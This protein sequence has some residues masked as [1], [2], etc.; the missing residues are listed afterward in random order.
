MNTDL[1]L[2]Q[3]VQAELR[4]EPALESGQIGVEAKN[5][6]VTLAGVVASYAVQWSAERAARRV[7]GVQALVARLKVRLPALYR[8]SDEDIARSACEVVT[9]ATSMPEGTVKVRVRAGRIT[10]SGRVDWPYQI[11]QAGDS[12]RYLRGVTGLNNRIGLRVRSAPASAEAAGRQASSRSYSHL[13]T[14]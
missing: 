7:A 13:T 10:L 14:V 8:R 9:S 4:W 12:V 3:A 1:Q 5:G 2:Q 6:I 11:E